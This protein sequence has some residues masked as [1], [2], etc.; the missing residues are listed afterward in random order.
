MHGSCVPLAGANSR[1]IGSPS[2]VPVVAQAYVTNA[3]ARSIAFY[4][5]QYLNQCGYGEEEIRRLRRELSLEN[6]TA[7]PFRIEEVVE[8]FAKQSAYFLNLYQRLI[9]GE[10]YRFVCEL[11]QDGRLA[12]VFRNYADVDDLMAHFNRRIFHSLVECKW[13]RHDYK[14]ETFHPNTGVFHEKMARGRSPFY[15]IG[16]EYLKEMRMR[17]CIMCDPQGVW[18]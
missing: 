8:S 6:I 9:D 1:A 15:V 17:A 13:M 12:S 11:S 2:H 10:F 14:E 3:V 7:S 16:I 18:P 5:V 4:A